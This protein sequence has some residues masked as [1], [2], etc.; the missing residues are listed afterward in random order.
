MCHIATHMHASL[1]I[2]RTGAHAPR[3][4]YRCYSIALEP[5]DMY[6]DVRRVC[7]RRRQGQGAARGTGRLAARRARCA[8]STP[9]SH[10]IHMACSM[11]PWLWGCGWVGGRERRSGAPHSR[12]TSDIGEMP[13][14]RREGGGRRV[15]SHRAP[16]HSRL[17]SK[18]GTCASGAHLGT[19]RECLAPDSVPLS[20]RPACAERARV[21][22]IGRLHRRRLEASSSSTAAPFRGS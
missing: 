19:F 12:S 5:D 16:Q 21:G 1:H 9:R 13:R 3:R 11:H 18:F 20:P 14:A 2:T 7:V 22:A 17:L 6:V 10:G 15:T 4:G 8:A